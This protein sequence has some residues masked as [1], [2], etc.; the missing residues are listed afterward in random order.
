MKRPPP[1]PIERVRPMRDMRLDARDLRDAS[2]HARRMVEWHVVGVHDTW[3]VAL[4]LELTVS[5]DHT[6]VV[7][8]PGLAYTA[9]GEALVLPRAVR[10]DAPATASGSFVDLAMRRGTIRDLGRCERPRTCPGE[11]PA[12]PVSAEVFWGGETGRP[13]GVADTGVRVGSEVPLGRFRRNVAG[14]LIGPDHSVRRAVRRFSRPHVGYGSVTADAL[15]WGGTWPW[16]EAT[17]DTRAAGF[18]VAPIY[19]VTLVDVPDPP[20]GAVGPFVEV[21]GATRDAFHL[22][23]NVASRAGSPSATLAYLDVLRTT[24]VNWFGAE[25][26]TG[27]PPTFSL[28]DFLTRFDLG[29][30]WS[31]VIARI[32]GLP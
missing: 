21:R 19:V 1:R 30:F 28:F 24:S 16:I 7:V 31:E 6:Q 9:R 10:L 32:G 29:S 14:R 18:S 20:E 11:R 17:V 8:A 26:M 25:S 4:G 2:D 3:G 5:D 12:P 15:Q 27:C 23:L 22:R 13:A